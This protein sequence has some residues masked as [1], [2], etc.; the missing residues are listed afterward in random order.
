MSMLNQIIGKSKA[1]VVLLLAWGYGAVL[2]AWF[3]GVRYRILRSQISTLKLSDPKR[4]YFILLSLL[5]VVSHLFIY[6]FVLAFAAAGCFLHKERQYSVWDHGLLMRELAEIKWISRLFPLHRWLQCIGTS[7]PNKA[8]KK[9]VVSSAL[10][11]NGARNWADS[12]IM[13]GFTPKQ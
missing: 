4:C 1:F 10:G 11:T 2:A 9:T 12:D 3:T 5:L 7:K 13:L 6:P 8:N